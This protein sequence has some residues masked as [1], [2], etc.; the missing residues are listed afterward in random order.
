MT[1]VSILDGTMKKSSSSSVGIFKSKEF[2]EIIVV[3]KSCI[4]Y[5]TSWIQAI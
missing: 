2:G 4:K 3:L 1:D 5:F